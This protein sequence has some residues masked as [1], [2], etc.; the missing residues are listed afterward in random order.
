MRA[1]EKRRE[2]R[3]HRPFI[4]ELRH[5]IGFDPL[6]V[7]RRGDNDQDGVRGSDS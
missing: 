2:W 6:R 1:V 5:R 3:T 7:G 4:E